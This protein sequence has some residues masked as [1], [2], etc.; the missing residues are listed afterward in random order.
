MW[1]LAQAVLLELLRNTF[2][3]GREP[4]EHPDPPAPILPFWEMRLWLEPE[5]RSGASE[6]AVEALP[7]AFLLEL[8]RGM[9]VQAVKPSSGP[10]HIMH[11]LI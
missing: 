10:Q 3:S 11:T 8:L 7:Q 1:A 5:P 4:Q 9:F 2:Y 6:R